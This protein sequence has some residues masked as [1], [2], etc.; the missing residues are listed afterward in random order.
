M[1]SKRTNTPSVLF[2]HVGWARN[3]VGAK[4]DVPQGKFG[5]LKEGN[6]DPGESSNFREFRGRCYGY[7]AHHSLTLSKL[8]G[9]ADAEYVDGVLVIWTATD[10]AAGGRYIIGWYRNARVHARIVDLRPEKKRRGIIAE[11][12]AKDC[13]VVPVDER[14][15]FIPSMI[16]GGWPGR[17]GAFYA[18]EKLSESELSK[19]LAYVGGEPSVGFYARD[20]DPQARSGK[21]KG[22]AP[23]DAARNAEVERAAVEV[24]TN[25][26]RPLFTVTSVEKDNE[27][28]DLNVT[29][30]GRCL[31]V[32]V[33]GRDGEGAV[34][35]TPNEWRAMNERRTRMSYRLAI[36]WNARS[37]SPHLMIFEYA[38]ASDHWIA[39][40]GTILKLRKMTGAIASF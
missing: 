22:R 16:K 4:D 7:A 17:P 15:F 31:L 5:Y 39:L 12:Q 18:N 3:Y 1:P 28:W 26:Y 24:V 11:A 30:G 23:T 8:G 13:R 36:V 34:E 37:K 21:S 14:T 33:K 32:E 40:C 2:L 9:S 38:P 25:H 20:H 10:P 27:G 29:G 19:V 35:L 6:E